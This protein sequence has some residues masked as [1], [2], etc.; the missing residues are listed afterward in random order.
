MSKP[1]AKCCVDIFE[2][3][4]HWEKTMTDVLAIVMEKEM[5][6][7]FD[8]DWLEIILIQPPWNL[9]ALLKCLDKHWIAVFGFFLPRELQDTVANLRFMLRTGWKPSEGRAILNTLNGSLSLLEALGVRSDYN[10]SVPQAHEKLTQ[11][12]R[13]SQKFLIKPRIECRQDTSKVLLKPRFKCG[14]STSKVLAKRRFERKQNTSKAQNN[15]STGS[16]L[17][18]DQP[19]QLMS[20]SQPGCGSTNE[21]VAGGTDPWVVFEE[22]WAALLNLTSHLSA[23]TYESIQ[24]PFEHLHSLTCAV[25]SLLLSLHRVVLEQGVGDGL[26]ELQFCLLTML[27]S[28]L[29]SLHPHDVSQASL[30]KCFS[31]SH[32]LQRLQVGAEQ[33]AVILGQ[34][35]QFCQAIWL[36]YQLQQSSNCNSQA[37]ATVI[38]S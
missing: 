18:S 1:D 34:L 38:A 13:E 30:Q 17:P 12:V 29:L 23:V 28:P 3:F 20:L 21:Y 11:L 27:R 37:T 5:H 8:E 10:G 35:Q 32:N 2:T 24:V 25:N 9:Q 33:L 16:H 15:S 14:Q 4:K 31:P 22:I 36:Y 19:T 6:L 7:A 26:S